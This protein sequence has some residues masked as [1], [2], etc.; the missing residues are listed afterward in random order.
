ME[1]I[2]ETL[3]TLC[4]RGGITPSCK[5]VLVSNHDRNIP[6]INDSLQKQ[7]QTLSQHN[8]ILIKQNETTQAFKNIGNRRVPCF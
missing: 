1:E 6:K 7:D 2:Q 5:T 4:L 3:K 8:E